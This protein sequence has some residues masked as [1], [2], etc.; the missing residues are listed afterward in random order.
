MK[1]I[2][3]HLEPEL[4]DWCLIEYR[5]ISK[6]VG[7]DNLIFTNIKKGKDKLAGLGEVKEESVNNMN[8]KNAC[9][10]EMDGK[11][12]LSSKD[13]FDSL[14]F[15]GILGDHPPQGRTLKHFK[16]W[17]GDKRNLGTEQMSTD[18]AVM[19]S[20]LI[21]D[22]ADFSK[23]KFQDEIEIPIEEGQSVIFPFRYLIINRKPFI[24]EELIEYLK[25][26]EEF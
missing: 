4:Y 9:L 14:V 3:E 23:L 16:N 21:V 25:K 24:S 7:K 5:H 19:V 18:N 6:A 2:I 22:G 20:K 10:M 26:T 12:T 11:Q 1:F 13:K 8:L 17:K 15:G